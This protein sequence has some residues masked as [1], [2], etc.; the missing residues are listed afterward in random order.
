VLP[1][2][3]PAEHVE[4][5]PGHGYF[6]KGS[7]RLVYFKDFGGDE[8]FH[9]VAVDV[10]SGRITDITAQQGGRQ[11]AD[12]QQAVGA[13]AQ[14]L[15]ISARAVYD[16][17]LPRFRF[18]RAVRY[19]Q[20]DVDAYKAACRST[21]TPATSAGASN[22]TATFKAAASGLLACFPKAGVKPRLTPT[23]APKAPASTRLRVAYSDP[24]P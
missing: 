24:I 4:E 10:A 6:W 15:G 16:L 8:N 21:G 5:W 17:P 7:G 13:L 1:P 12:T 11:Q 14:Q 19:E 18:G 2:P 9:V 3:T 23:T 20:S 22:S